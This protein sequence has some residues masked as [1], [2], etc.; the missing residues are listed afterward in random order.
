MKS[1]S[2]FARLHIHWYIFSQ[3]QLADVHYKYPRLTEERFEM[4]S[5]WPQTLEVIFIDSILPLVVR[6]MQGVYRTFH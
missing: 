6:V 3:E 5:L 2:C 1:S 4:S